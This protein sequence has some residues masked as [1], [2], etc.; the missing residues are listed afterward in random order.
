MRLPFFFWE[1][2]GHIKRTVRNDPRRRGCGRDRIAKH[3]MPRVSLGTRVRLIG[4][5]RTFHG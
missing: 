4:F 2:R 5:R 3:K 1:K